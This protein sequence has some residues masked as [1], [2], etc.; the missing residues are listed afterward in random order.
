MH[1]FLIQLAIKTD[2]TVVKGTSDYSTLKEATVAFHVAMS[3]GMQN[4]EIQK[5][6][7]LVVDENG[8]ALTS[9]TYNA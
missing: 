4:D 5:L 2:E 8:M 3:S 9:E 1:Y 6:T 7:C